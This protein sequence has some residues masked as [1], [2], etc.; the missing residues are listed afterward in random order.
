[1]TD[2]GSFVSGVFGFVAKQKQQQIHQTK[3]NTMLYRLVARVLLLVGDLS[4]ASFT[5]KARC[6]SASILSFAQEAN[7]QGLI[8]KLNVKG[9]LFTMKIAQALNYGY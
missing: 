9:M 7:P 1:M 3:R 4:C 5:S 8:C 6:L 2:H